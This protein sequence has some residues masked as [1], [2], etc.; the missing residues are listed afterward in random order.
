MIQLVQFDFCAAGK[1]PAAK[2]EGPGKESG[3][4]AILTRLKTKGAAE[5]EK[6]GK[7]GR[8]KLEEQSEKDRAKEGKVLEETFIPPELSALLSAA[9]LPQPAENQTAETLDTAQPAPALQPAVSAMTLKADAPAAAVAQAQTL[10]DLPTQTQKAAQQGTPHAFEIP[11]AGERPPDTEAISAKAAVLEPNAKTPAAPVQPEWQEAMPGMKAPQA[12]PGS[13]TEIHVSRV[14]MA[15]PREK[16][17]AMDT[18]TD[19]KIATATGTQM[20]EPV[21]TVKPAGTAAQP[22]AANAAGEPQR[23]TPKRDFEVSA[24]KEP[25]QKAVD[26]GVIEK[27]ATQQTEET[28]PAKRA[29]DKATTLRE[30]DA[31]T[32]AGV[33]LKFTGS[34]AVAKPSSPD[35]AGQPQ[36]PVFEQ[37][38]GEVTRM[39]QKMPEEGS[40][41]FDMKL[42][43]AGL[44]KLEIRM[45]CEGKNLALTVTAHSA[46]AAKLLSGGAQELR[47]A[48]SQNYE[49]TH[50]DIRSEVKAEPQSGASFFANGFSESRHDGGAYA[51]GQ[52]RYAADELEMG[53]NA[54]AQIYIPAGMLSV[55][56]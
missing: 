47:E 48:L 17:P 19:V 49:V 43:P 5:G 45:T 53:A 38:A 14:S 29:P 11:A 23:A 16:A 12:N 41:T 51:Q 55:R 2:A 9:P 27:K 36:R 44:G 26:A 39:S 7:A 4:E 10:P 22:A 18:D 6:E 21:G 15:A 1:T 52:T 13:P 8:V 54:T 33:P 28:E 34:G 50:L 3:F 46:E 31:V 20:Q 42:F 25:M 32:A 56:V 30:G 35:G 24:P 40:C 37:V